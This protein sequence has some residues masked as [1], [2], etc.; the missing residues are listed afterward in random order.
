M[1][2]KLVSNKLENAENILLLK[3]NAT[4]NIYHR[5]LEVEKVYSTFPYLG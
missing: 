4:S 1:N 2:F 5:P 3:I